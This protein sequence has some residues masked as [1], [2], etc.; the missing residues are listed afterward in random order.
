MSLDP[1]K[2][3]LVWNGNEFPNSTN[4][5][6][7]APAGSTIDW[8]DGTVETFDTASTA[9]NTHTYTDGK[10][11]HTIVISGLTSIGDV[12]FDSCSGL[13]SVMIGNSVT[14]IGN[15]AFWTCSK[16]TSVTIPNSVTSIGRIAFSYCSRLTSIIIPDS[17]T[18]I[19]SGAFYFCDNLIQLVLFPETPPTLASDSIPNNI[20]SIY[21]QQSSQAAYQAAAN[22]AAFADKIVVD[23]LYLS[24][25]RFNQK[26]KE[27]IN[28]KISEFT[29]SSSIN[30]VQ[31]TGNSETDVM[32]QKAVT[33]YFLPAERVDNDYFINGNINFLNYDLKLGNMSD[34][35]WEEA[36]GDIDINKPSESGRMAIEPNS[37]PTET[38]LVTVSSTGTHGY[39]KVSELVDTTSTQIIT[40][41]KVFADT[42]VIFRDTSGN[43]I[44]TQFHSGSIIHK[45]GE[46]IYL[47]YYPSASGT[48]ALTPNFAPTE[49]SVV[50]NDVDRTPTWKPISELGGGGN[51]LKVTVW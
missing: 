14:S 25:V 23:N 8:G 34:F 45:K 39:K 29:P 40:G 18:S 19:G 9:V 44:E 41:A 20:Q 43:N 5:Q 36:G 32:S 4:A 16:L 49:P 3:Y 48:V 37:N 31:T 6:F 47:F 15:G 27:Y 17:V 26:N 7:K 42:P 46:T 38:S 13:T 12:W 22:W 51:A 1:N 10:T 2:T 50:V 35:L 30:V 21:V 28:E 33:Q 11:E 24:F